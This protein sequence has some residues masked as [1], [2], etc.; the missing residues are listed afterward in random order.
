MDKGGIIRKLENLGTRSLP[1]KIS[2]HGQ[3]NR[4]G[5]YFIVQFD[6]PTH[7]IREVAEEYGRDIDIVRRQIFSLEEPLTKE[8]TLAEELM[9]PAYRKDVQKMIAIAKK[10]EKT[11]FSEKS[12]LDYY[13]FQR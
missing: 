8:C 3:V 12:G 7:M 10:G 6:L 13:P 1:H 2:E 5:N 9:S 11:K 4:T